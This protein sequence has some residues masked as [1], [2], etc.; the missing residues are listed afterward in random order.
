MTDGAIELTGSDA[1][2]IRT[3]LRMKQGDEIIVSAG[4][5]G[6]YRC[7]IESVEETIGLAVIEKMSIDK[8]PLPVITLYQSIAKG[9][10]MDGIVRMSCEMGVAR[11][12]PI[13]TERCDVKLK[14]GE[15][16][17]ARKLDRWKAISLSA[18]KQSKAV[19]ATIIDSPVTLDKVAGSGDVN[20]VFWEVEAQSLKPVL[21]NRPLPSSINILIGPEGGFTAEEVSLLKDRGFI[22]ASLGPKTLRTETA[23]IVAVAQVLYHFSE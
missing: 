15:E 3:V 16:N 20:L 14:P 6:R 12:I 11:L 4:A 18:A 19:T 10:K 23:P 8:N 22:S 9:R 1:R 13:I 21:E 2:H 5:K 17:V 7:R